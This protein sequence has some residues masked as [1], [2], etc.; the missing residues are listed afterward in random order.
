MKEQAPELREHNKPLLE[1]FQQ[2]MLADRIV[3]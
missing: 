2:L 1:S 3:N